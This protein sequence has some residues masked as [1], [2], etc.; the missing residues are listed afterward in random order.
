MVGYYPAESGIKADF[1]EV[2]GLEH[3]LFERIRQ[4]VSVKNNLSMFLSN[5]GLPEKWF[6]LAH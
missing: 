2:L 3:T 5:A 4:H 1:G 6:A